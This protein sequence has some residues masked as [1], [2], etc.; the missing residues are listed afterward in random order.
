MPSRYEVSRMKSATNIHHLHEVRLMLRYIKTQVFPKLLYADI[1]SDRCY[2]R[3]HDLLPSDF[4]Q[5]RSTTV[6]S[7]TMFRS[8][9]L[10]LFAALA[11]L[12][13]V[14]AEEQIPLSDV[15]VP[16]ACAYWYSPNN[17]CFPPRHDVFISDGSCFS[18]PG[19]CMGINKI[20]EGCR[21]FIYKG[22]DCTGEEK[23]VGP[24]N[25]DWEQWNTR[26]YYT[27]KAFCG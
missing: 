16:S 10:T 15:T 25:I 2:I 26:D 9:P 3:D 13:L 6:E 18:L 27:I 17:D 1:Q 21:I 4:T 11:T 19:K 7:I 8:P 23:Q 22:K 24:D 12:R 14:H 20:H 5:H